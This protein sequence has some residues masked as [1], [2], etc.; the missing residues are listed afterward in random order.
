[1]L[2][3]SET[4]SDERDIGIRTFGSG[5][6]D[7]LVRTASAGITFACTLGFGTGTMLYKKL[8]A[9]V[10]GEGRIRSTRFRRNEFW[11]GLEGCVDVCTVV[12]LDRGGP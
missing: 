1:M 7:L 4:G 6:A 8:L 3:R 12:F 9:R 5:G 11:S 2:D 10:C